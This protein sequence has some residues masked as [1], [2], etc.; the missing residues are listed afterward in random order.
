MKCA[1]PLLKPKKEDVK[2]RP[3]RLTLQIPISLYRDLMDE[4]KAQG[5]NINDLCMAKLASTTW[6]LRR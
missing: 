5:I 4:T 3:R 2:P 6:W 1:K